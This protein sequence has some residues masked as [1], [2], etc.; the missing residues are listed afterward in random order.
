MLLADL[1]FPAEELAFG[2][3][4]V[5]IRSPRTVSLGTGESVGVQIR[6]GSFWVMPQPLELLSDPALAVVVRSSSTWSGSAGSVWP[7]SPPSSRRRFGAGGAGPS[8]S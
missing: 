8:T 2:H 1:A 6:P 3:T 4:K 7:S 5:F